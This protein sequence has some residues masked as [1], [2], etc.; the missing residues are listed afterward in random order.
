MKRNIVIAILPAD[1][2]FN[3]IPACMENDKLCDI[4]M[5]GNRCNIQRHGSMFPLTI[6][7]II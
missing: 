7:V 3:F 4:M 2:N 6:F 1:G 5:L